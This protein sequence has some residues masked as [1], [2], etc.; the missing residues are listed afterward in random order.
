M[1]PL[2]F[3]VTTKQDLL[4]DLEFTADDYEVRNFITNETNFFPLCRINQFK[5]G[6]LYRF[7]KLNN[8]TYLSNSKKILEALPGV[9]LYVE[10]G[11]WMKLDSDIDW[12][13]LPR[14]TTSNNYW[15]QA[16]SKDRLLNIGQYFDITVFDHFALEGILS[17]EAIIEYLQTRCDALEKA[18][19][20]HA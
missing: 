1:P 6:N 15:R 3:T 19:D 10:E 2:K 18:I 4:F 5:V 7:F 11:Y 20:Y 8:K 13:H 16:S 14:H 9:W 12:L 17:Q